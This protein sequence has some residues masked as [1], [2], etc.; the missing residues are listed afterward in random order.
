MKRLALLAG[1]ALLAFTVTNCGQKEESM[2]TP[3][4]EA[5][6]ETPATETPATTDTTTMMTDTTAGADTTGGM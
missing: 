4:T 6:T 2:E 5:A 3:A 1:L